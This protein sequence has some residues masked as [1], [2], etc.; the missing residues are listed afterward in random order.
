MFR[1]M[2]AEVVADKGSPAAQQAK[3]LYEQLKAMER[4]GTLHPSL[5]QWAGEIRVIGNAGAHPSTLAAVDLAEARELSQLCRRLL[6]VV[7]ETPARISRARAARQ[8]PGT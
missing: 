1:G 2:L 8:Q 7:Y 5:V 3:T 6:D 4:E